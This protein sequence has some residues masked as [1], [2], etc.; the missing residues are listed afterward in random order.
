MQSLFQRALSRI[1]INTFYTSLSAFSSNFNGLT[2]PGE[3]GAIITFK[4]TTQQDYYDANVSGA[5]LYNA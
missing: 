3:S 5:D 2:A 4:C 1:N